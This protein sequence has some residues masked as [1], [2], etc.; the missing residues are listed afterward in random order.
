MD[1][2]KT[3]G[4]ISQICPDD[5]STWENKNF[6][7][8]DIDWAHDE[9]LSE[10]IDLMEKADV[11]AT[12][13]VTHYTPLLERL[14]ANSKFELG[15]HPNF[16]FL[17]VG[18]PRNGS[19]AEEVVDR[20]L[21]FNPDTKVVRSHSTTQSSRLLELFFKKG[22]T[23][24]CNH[25]IPEQAMIELKPFK[26]WTNLVKIPYFWE[27]AAVCISEVNTSI[28]QLTQRSGLRVFNFHPIHIYL[29]TDKLSRYEQA[30][31]NFQ[32]PSKLFKLRNQ[33]STGT[34]DKLRNL[35]EI[36]K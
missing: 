5:P 30:R 31:P 12:W 16:N 36:V 25:F 4:N 24:D 21:E 8:F 3:F 7:T 2:S 14:R 32:N 34:K 13:F 20:L 17:L 35:L 10:T 23:H 6:I 15:I 18:D 27:D 19:S 26:C 9:I 22:I 29:N 1:F 28:H 11:N 33:D